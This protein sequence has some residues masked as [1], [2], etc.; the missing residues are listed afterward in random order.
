M[1]ELAFPL[2]AI[3][4]NTSNTTIKTTPSTENED[5]EKSREKIINIIR[6]NPSVTQFE[7]STILQISTK[8]IENK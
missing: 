4:K 5:R 2:S 7:L 8:V 3:S 6:K 1:V